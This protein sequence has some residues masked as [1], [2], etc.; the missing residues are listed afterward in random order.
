M[1]MILISA[2]TFFYF[3]RYIKGIEQTEVMRIFVAQAYQ[4]HGSLDC[5][6]ID[7]Q[8]RF[9]IDMLYEKAVYDLMMSNSPQKIN[10]TYYLII[11]P[12]RE[13]RVS[14]TQP[15]PIPSSDGAGFSAAQLAGRPRIPN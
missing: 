5:S 10:A 4:T 8:D 2:I 3:L 9:D 13:T 12:T 11:G 14:K 15:H 7:P 6:A 1:V